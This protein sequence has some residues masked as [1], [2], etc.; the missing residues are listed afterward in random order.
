[1]QMQNLVLDPDDLTNPWHAAVASAAS[2]TV[3]SIVPIVAILLPSAAY[4]VPV[5][6]TS[7][8]IALAIT[9]MLSAKVGGASPVRATI[10]VVAGGA[11]AMA[12]TYGVGILCGVSGI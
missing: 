4:R 7:V 9:G 12:A 5:A 1:M 2:F 6:F 10:R 3:G 11:L 8:I